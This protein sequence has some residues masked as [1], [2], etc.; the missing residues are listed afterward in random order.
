M[1]SAD[2]RKKIEAATAF[3]FIL[4]LSAIAAC[5]GANAKTEKTGA[6]APSAPVVAKK[7]SVGV[8]T[9]KGINFASFIEASGTALPHRVSVLSA[10]VPGRIDEI[11]VKA[12]SRVRKGQPLVRF[13]QTGYS[14]SLKQAEAGVAAATAGRD[15]MKLE[16]DRVKQLVDSDAAAKANFDRMD[17]QLRAAEAQLQLAEAGLGQAR[18]AFAD[19]TLVAPYE[20]TV[21]EVMK[22]LGEYAPS[23]PPTMLVKLVDTSELEVQTFLSEENTGIVKV[24]DEAE[25]RID[26]ADAVVT[27][28][29]IF[30]SDALVQGS[31][32]FEVRIHL[33]NKDG[34]IMGG[35]FSR[36][37]FPRTQ[38][39]KA[40]LVPTRIVRRTE[41][42]KPYVFVVNAGRADQRPL[43]LG[44]TKGDRVLV[45]SGLTPGD[46]VV[47]EGV[48]D[49]NGGEEVDTRQLQ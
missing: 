16:Y 26:A 41:E 19:S 46:S 17:A 30:V 12:G 21:V 6:A 14:L 48:S 10:S 4:T 2:A 9:V 25:V 29:V 39:D 18:K 28:K 49:L 11:F 37:K 47:M 24:G 8:E 13:D 34:K 40:V 43:E 7:K 5:N 3:L 32:N 20:S 45:L 38:T 42:G 15:G 22:E 44:E 1:S 33:D 35:A 27:G 31:Q 36:V 23:M